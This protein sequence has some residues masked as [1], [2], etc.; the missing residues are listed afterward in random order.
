[1][2][3][4]RGAPRQVER[5]VRVTPGELPESSGLTAQVRPHEVA[6][7]DGYLGGPTVSSDLESLGRVTNPQRKA[8]VGDTNPKKAK[9]PKKTKPAAPPPV[10]SAPAAPAKG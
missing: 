1:M 2:A 7:G 10:K 4:P 6:H 8:T 9:K 5:N 3:R